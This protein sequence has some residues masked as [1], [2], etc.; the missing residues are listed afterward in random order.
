[1]VYLCKKNADFFY[2]VNFLKVYTYFHILGH[3]GYQTAD[4]G[5]KCGDAGKYVFFSSSTIGESE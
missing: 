4:R 3:K 2:F 5:K 1:M